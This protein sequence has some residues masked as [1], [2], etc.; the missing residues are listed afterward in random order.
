MPLVA[1][2][3]AI[4]GR[5][6]TDYGIGTYLTHLLRGVG[7]RPGIDLT[8][9]TRA[10]H[11]ERVRALAPDALVVP[12]SASG[13]SAAEHWQ[14][15]VALWNHPHDLVHVPHYVI[16]F[17]IRAPVVATIH[18]VIQLFYP[19][20]DRAWQALV[21]LRMM[22][23]LTLRRARHVITVSRASRRDLLR[24]FGADRSKI[25]VIPNGVEEHLAQRPEDGV[26]T[27]LKRR[28]DLKPPLLLAVGNDKAHK[29]LDTVL[30]VFHQAVRRYQ[31]PGQLVFVGGV[32][33][34]GPISRR[35]ERLGLEGRVRVVGRVPTEDLHGLYHASSV[36]IHLA[37]YEGFGY[38]ILE[39]MHAGLP[40]VTANLGAMQELGEGAAL[41][42]NPLDVNGAA[43]ALDQVL[44]DDPLRRRMREAGRRRAN[45]LTWEKMIETTVDVY[46]RV[47]GIRT[48][49]DAA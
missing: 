21:Y 49:E 24:I 16:P 25:T 20:P 7:E 11:E 23:R 46:R 36:L 40:V 29:N 44:L 19:P 48:E 42:V 22:I 45:R 43:A 15:P 30:R 17:G 35:A 18:D 26:L 10:G 2:R 37:L 31:I 9:V 28:L 39:A 3:L 5:K 13:Y 14:I 32:D 34:S 6:L 33:P 12:V 38:P 27:A 8:V 4:D 1:M 41:L 47:S